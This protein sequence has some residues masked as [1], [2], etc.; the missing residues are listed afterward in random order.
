MVP[1]VRMIGRNSNITWKDKKIQPVFKYV[2][3]VYLREEKTRK[4]KSSQWT[5][6]S[7]DNYYQIMD[8][9]IICTWF[10]ANAYWTYIK[11]VKYICPSMF[12]VYVFII[13]DIEKLSCR[14]RSEVLTVV[15]VCLIFVDLVLFSTLQIWTYVRT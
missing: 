15:A 14:C 4:P 5:D 7:K 10:I 12:L 6:D 3:R 1:Y 11:I 2:S 13:I 9:N 8:R